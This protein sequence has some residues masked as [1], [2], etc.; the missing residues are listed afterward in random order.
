[1]RLRGRGDRMSN[2]EDHGK[3]RPWRLYLL[4]SL[5]MAALLLLVLRL[6]QVQVQQGG[7]HTRTTLRQSIRP[8]RLNPVRGRIVSADGVVL[9]D[10]GG[11]FDVVYHLAE[12]RQSHGRTVPH[13]LD[14]TE[15]LA[16]LLGRPAPIAEAD[17]MRHFRLR[18]ALPMT[19]FRDLSPRE[20]AVLAEMVPPVQGVEIV[21]RAERTYRQ[22]GFA[23][24]VLGHTGPERPETTAEMGR[25]PLAYVSPELRGWAGIE[26]A[27][28]GE[29]SGVAGSRLVRVSAVGYVYE[30]IGTAVLPQNGHDVVLTLDSR[31]QAAAESALASDTVHPHKAMVL[32][33]VH[34]GAVLAM[35][36]MPGYDL[37]S[38]DASGFDSAYYTALERDRDNRPLLNRAMQTYT[39]GSILKPLIGLAA[40]EA[41]AIRPFEAYECTGYFALSETERIHCWNPYGQGELNFV[42]AVATSCNPY[43]VHAALATGLDRIGPLLAAAGIGR[44][45]ALDLPPQYEPSERGL[46]PS[47]E[48]LLEMSGGRRAWAYADTAFLG[49]GQGIIGVTPLQ[50]ALYTAAIA[51]GGLVQRPFLVRSVRRLDGV[52]VRAA[53]PVAESRLP[54]SEE[55]LGLVRQGMHDAVNDPHGTAR[56]AK[57]AVASLAGKTGTAEVATRGDR[58]KDTWFIGFGPVED[59]RYAVAVLVEHGDTGGKTAAPLAKVFFEE[60]LGGGHAGGE[61]A[62]AGG[63]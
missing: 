12:M 24:H 17:V 61:N 37:S 25:Y 49:I 44:R 39:P 52:E 16:G 22:P 38:V 14:V 28:D 43:F 19:V 45:P 29:L 56:G 21:C 46:C 50:A 47:R 13:V 59:P 30:E 23:C 6:W 20:L 18:P 60:W 40:L 7:A 57:N 58:H 35:A 15:R 63:W 26:K 34:T 42:E 32:V 10:N 33:E 53:Q 5:L 54:V 1:M 62:S 11:V 36:S 4:G 55:H 8:I 48:G 9:V 51:N 2:D 31:A 41:G 3:A 27:Y